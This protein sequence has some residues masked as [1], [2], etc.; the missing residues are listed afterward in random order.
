MGGY[1]N[2]QIPSDYLNTGINV[3]SL[4]QSYNTQ[5]TTDKYGFNPSDFNFGGQGLNQATQNAIPNA[6]T[7]F[8]ILGSGA[9]PDIPDTGF[10]WMGAL[11]KFGTVAQGFGN[12]ASGYGQYQA[13]KAALEANDINKKQLAKNNKF[14]KIN[15]SDQ[16]GHKY[17]QNN[18]LVSNHDLGI[19]DNASYSDRKAFLDA[20]QKKFVNLKLAGV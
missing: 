12:L 6:S 3:P 11:N 9:F 5:T 7:M 10:D 13:G 2:F 4:G 1:S 15:I 16:L 20:G 18:A 14:R 19:A 8:P 17:Q